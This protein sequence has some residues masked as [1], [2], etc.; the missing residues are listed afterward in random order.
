[1]GQRYDCGVATPSLTWC[2]VFLLE[3]G[4]ISSSSYC[5]VFHQRS[6]PVS[7]G[8]LSTPKSLAFWRSR[9][10]PNL[11]FLEVACL[12]FFLL[13]L[14]DSVLFAHWIPDQ[15]PLAPLLTPHQAWVV[16]SVSFGEFQSLWLQCSLLFLYCFCPLCSDKI[17]L[18][19]ISSVYRY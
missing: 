7:S 19:I 14:R 15:V 8:S 3:V 5:W 2:P 18:Y 9:G 13:A 10:Y 11:L 1:M 17:A 4:S 6:L 12:H 16:F